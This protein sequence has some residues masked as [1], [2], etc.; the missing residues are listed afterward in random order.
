MSRKTDTPFKESSP[1]TAREHNMPA[2][3]ATKL[4]RGAALSTAL[5]FTFFA[6][7]PANAY[8]VRLGGVDIQ[9]DTTLSAGVQIRTAERDMG[10]GYVAELN[11]GPASLGALTPVG[12]W[13]GHPGTGD[14]C[15]GNEGA[16]GYTGYGA[17]C[18]FTENAA[19]G[20]N[21]AGS[22]NQDNG[23]L[24]FDEGDIIG[25]VLKGTAEIEAQFSNNLTG[26]MRVNLF[27]D[28]VLGDSGSYE[29]EQE[30]DKA[31]VSG[32][33][34]LL[35]AYI[36]YDLEL[37]GNP[38]L[39]RVG[40]QVINWGEATFSL[41]GNAFFNPVDVNALIRPGSEIKEA[42]IPVGAAYASLALPYNLTAEAYVALEHREFMV[43][44]PGTPFS[45]SDVVTKTEKGTFGQAWLGSNPWSGTKFNCDLGVVD[46]G[47]SASPVTQSLA[48][49]IDGVLQLSTSEDCL[50]GTVDWRDRNNDI[51]RAARGEGFDRVSDVEG[52]ESGDFGL[53]LRWYSE[54]L[55]STEFGLFYQ[56]ADS[57][58]PYGQWVSNGPTLN[59][60]NKGIQ[61][62]VVGRVLTGTSCL[63]GTGNAANAATPADTIIADATFAL[64]PA[65]THIPA[66]V[67]VADP[68]GIAS[69][70]ATHTNNLVG[71][72]L[73]DI[74]LSDGLSLT[75]SVRMICATELARFKANDPVYAHDSSL[76]GFPGV[77]TANGELTPSLSQD[78][79]LR[80]VYPEDIEVI[81]LSFNT[82]VAGWGLQGEVAYKPDFPLNMDSNDAFLGGLIASCIFE[83][84]PVFGGNLNNFGKTLA[85]EQNIGCSSE[86]QTVD[87]WFEEDIIT[88]NV[89]TTAT[90]TR[91]NPVAAFLGAD[92]LVLL[93]EFNGVY[94]DAEGDHDMASAGEGLTAEQ[95]DITSASVCT[96]GTDIAAGGTFSI[97]PVPTG[98][99]AYIGCR[100]TRD[101]YE[102]IV[103]FSAQYNN[104]FG[105]PVSLSPRLV[106]R[107][108]LSGI[109]PRPAASFVE[110]VSS[111][112]IGVS[113]EYQGKWRA[114]LGYT[115][116]GGD[117]LYTK[118]LDR[119]FLSLDVS[120]AF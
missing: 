22:P 67:T 27:A 117:R 111:T 10:K 50:T 65:T 115:V 24:N 20:Y 48:A 113:A 53:A 40:R 85:A 90:F 92:L 49:A 82:T 42:F 8:N 94:F 70:I 52:D 108:G 89:G 118:N 25:G 26:F 112:N 28:P 103:L 69:A 64:D 61:A 51:Q 68:K 32:D 30:T 54:T 116:Y 71:S 37:A 84:F 114:S 31:D 5:A 19:T 110:G 7:Q 44:N 63:N 87:A 55:N 21:Y 39:I 78:V 75:E 56:Q 102:G 11:G 73:S 46:G 86:Q 57:R 3:K 74:D 91:S 62:S 15:S 88:Y 97:D 109:A 41:G 33:L 105:S 66:G 104:V 18:T 13:E 47:T 14:L 80:L 59:Y 107:E 17:H 93:T 98:E 101:A 1:S 6:S 76:S 120:Y 119:D 95:V 100:A 9:I 83:Q 81:G 96:Y 77:A 12:A 16:P 35:D 60:S 106:H 2:S 29:R 79:D 23:R 43:P 45:G 34:V 99:S 36:S 72:D 38:M 58:I 4:I